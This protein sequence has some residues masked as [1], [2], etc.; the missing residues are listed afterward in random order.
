MYLSGPMKDTSGIDLKIMV[1]HLN[2]DTLFWP[3]E[4]KHWPVN[5]ERRPIIAYKFQKLF[6]SLIHKRSLLS[7]V[8]I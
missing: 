6:K 7:R 8:T 1:H 2:I 3:I 4:Q 5:A